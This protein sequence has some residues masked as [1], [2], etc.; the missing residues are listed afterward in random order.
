MGVQLGNLKVLGLR[1]YVDYCFSFVSCFL[2]ALT[3]HFFSSY[4][5]N[6][7]IVIAIYLYCSSLLFT[8]TAP[9]FLSPTHSHMIKTDSFPGQEQL[10]STVIF[11]ANSYIPKGLRRDARY[12]V[13]MVE[14]PPLPVHQYGEH[15]FYSFLI[16]FY[17]V[18]VVGSARLLL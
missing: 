4:D 12:V 17:R 18:R 3:Y 9:T 1:G 8:T 16:L 13:K 11:P 6:F 10:G 15:H 5:Y 7:S 14:I 2:L